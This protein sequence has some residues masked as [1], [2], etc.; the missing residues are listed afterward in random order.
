MSSVNYTRRI[1]PASLFSAAVGNCA[2]HG[3]RWW[4]LNCYAPSSGKEDAGVAAATKIEY[5][6]NIFSIRR[7]V[8]WG[9][10]TCRCENVRD[11]GGKRFR[12]CRNDLATKKKLRRVRCNVSGK[13]SI[14]N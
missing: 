6:L 12:V 8:S 13:E 5:D 7:A 11:A 1:N 9:A 2:A 10:K 14:Q 3:A 4:S